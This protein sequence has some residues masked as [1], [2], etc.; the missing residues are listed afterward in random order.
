MA[1]HIDTDGN[2]YF[3]ASGTTEFDSLSYTPVFSVTKDGVLT[4]I[5][6]AVGGIVLASDHIKSSNY[7]ATAGQE[8][9]FRI[10]SNGDAVFNDVTIRGDL[11]GV[12]LKGEM[13]FDSSGN[14][15]IKT[16][17]TGTRVE[18][19]D[20]NG[21][22]GEIRFETS[23]GTTA[24]LV[25]D[26]A[27]EFTIEQSALSGG[28]IKLITG[29]TSDGLQF[30]GNEINITTPLSSGN[31]V[32]K[33]NGT[34]A[35]SAGTSTLSKILGVTSSGRLAVGS[36]TSG[37]S[38]ISGSGDIAVTGS[39]GVLNIHHDDSDHSFADSGHDHDTDY[40]S[41]SAGSLL[42]SSLTNHTSN[43]SAH[44]TF[45]NYSSWTLRGNPGGNLQT[46]SIGS[47]DNA[48]I[49][50]GSG[51]TA[52]MSGSSITLNSSGVT[53]IGQSGTDGFVKSVSG[54][55]V[56]TSPTLGNI[57]IRTGSH[58]PE[59][60]FNNLGSS[61]DRWYRL[62]S[63]VSTSVSSD[64]RLKENIVDINQGLDFINNLRPVEFTWRD[65]TEYACEDYPDDK[66]NKTREFC[67]KCQKEND[68]AYSIYLLEK[69]RFDN[70]VIEDEPTEPTFT[71]CT[72]VETTT[73]INEGKKS[74]GMIAQEVETTLGDY[75]GQVLNHDTENDIYGL[76]YS[77]FVAPL[78]KAV[79]E[80]ST[81][82]SDLTAR[83][84]ALEG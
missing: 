6:G 27:T 42:A 33:L 37:V 57:A 61:N 5:S 74:W 69:E 2:F 71:A 84:E 30:T 21:I 48:S 49:Y 35:N 50:A 78:I 67:S 59:S 70:E 7:S 31:P 55:T 62:Y 32:I 45:D 28:K 66:Y 38:S 4:A 76:S 52:S 44:G 23:S 13:V 16:S 9:G 65:V 15:S 39:S 54:S 29:T 22:E 72:W 53:S 80:L 20:N 46:S 24:R 81:Q 1:I 26:A 47:G 8:A 56:N 51:I 41:S 14:G 82:I 58:Y 68:T 43:S 12:E 79:Q 10:N 63:Q 73:D 83:V 77:S 34:N 17:T 36:A 18:I 19:L 60:S 11:F 40:Y 3:G 75:D 25:A 64:E